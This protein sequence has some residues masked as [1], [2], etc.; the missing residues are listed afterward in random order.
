MTPEEATAVQYVGKPIKFDVPEGVEGP[1]YCVGDSHVGV[2]QNIFPDFFSPSH[3]SFDDSETVYQSKSAY[4][5]GSDGH[6]EYLEKSYRSIPQGSKV[7]MSFGE[8]DC[9]H[10]LPRFRNQR[11]VPMEEL[12]DEVIDRYKLQCLNRF[13][14]KYRLIILGVY[15]TPDDH[16]HNGIQDKESWSNSYENIFEAK[17]ILNEK[18]EQYCDETGA[19]FV[20]IWEVSQK[21]QWD[22]HPKGTY[23]GDASHASGCMVPVILDAMVDFKWKGFDL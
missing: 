2:L 14:E 1:V 22:A 19:L 10:Y 17:Q 21:D 11:G 7:L 4:A 3:W 15:M 13:L 5:V 12:V 16:G 9:R 20:P 8:I 6:G 18:L 23:F